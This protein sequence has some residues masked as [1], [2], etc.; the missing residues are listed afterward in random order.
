M[1]VDPEALA[2]ELANPSRLILT[3]TIPP[4]TTEI[5]LHPLILLMSI[6]APKNQAHPPLTM[7]IQKLR[8]PIT[9][10]LRHTTI[11]TAAL[12]LSLTTI[13][14]TRKRS[15]PILLACC[16][17]FP[18]LPTLILTVT[19]LLSKLSGSRSNQTHLHSLRRQ[20]S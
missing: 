13:T 3:K 7:P 12:P 18:C 8:R 15:I 9:A 6:L 19:P 20:F 11:L 10:S 2:R 4:S 14:L 1:R 5:G 17:H 16:H